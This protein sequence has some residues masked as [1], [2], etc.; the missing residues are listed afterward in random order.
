LELSNLE[1][2]RLEE[3]YAQSMKTDEKLSKEEKYLYYGGYDP[4]TITA[5]HILNNKAGVD[6][7]SYSHTA[8]P[9][10]V[11]AIGQGSEKFNGYYDNTDIPKKIKESGKL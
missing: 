4:F 6:W 5:T 10:A 9:V 2:K 3:A 7:A 11:F 1:T 8:V